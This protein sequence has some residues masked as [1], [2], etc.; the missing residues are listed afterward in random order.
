MIIIS[1]FTYFTGKF[2]TLQGESISPVGVGAE[3]NQSIIVHNI[4]PTASPQF[5]NSKNLK[6][7]YIT[8]SGSKYHKSTC[9]HIQKSATVELS[10]EDAVNAGY[11]PCKDCMQ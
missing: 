5:A 11:E 1:S 4:P 3:Y 8:P 10:I 9:R 6:P 2:S 7:V